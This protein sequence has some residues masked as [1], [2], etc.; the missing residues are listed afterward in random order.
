MKILFYGRLGEAIGRE[1]DF[2]PGTA[3]TVGALKEALVA[4]WPEHAAE[5][6]SERSKTVIADAFVHDDASLAGISHI[7]FL[8]PVSGG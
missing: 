1:I 6:L 7:E 5:L 8:P 2:D 3:Q 4:A